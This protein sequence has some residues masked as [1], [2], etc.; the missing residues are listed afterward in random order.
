MN[1]GWWSRLRDPRG[2][3]TSAGLAL[4]AAAL[5]L[6]NLG[7]PRAFVFD[8]TYYAKDAYSLLRFGYERAFTKTA[9]ASILQG[10]LD[11]FTG[12]PAYVVHPPLGKWMIAAGEWLFGMNPFGWRIVAAV[13]GVAMVVLV[14]RIA[15]RVFINP[16]TAA[17]AGLFM[18]IDGVAIV[19]SRTALLDQF[20]TF[21]VL[22]TFYALVRDRSEYRHTLALLAYGQPVSRM[23]TARPWRLL[24]IVCIS[25]ALATKW[26]ALWFAFG[27]VLLAMWWDG[28]ERRS[29]PDVDPQAWLKDVGWLGISVLLGAATYAATWLGWFVSDAAYDRDKTGNTLLSWLQYQQSALAF[30]TNLT[31]DHPYKAAPYGW[32]LQLR[33]TSFWFESYTNGQHGCAS[34]QCSAEVLALGNPVVWWGASLAGIVL[35]A[36]FLLRRPTRIEWDRLSGPAM[37]IVAGWLPWVYFHE[38]TTFAFYSIV[39]APFM[40]L[41]FA[42][43]LTQFATKLVVLD[44]EEFSI[45]VEELHERR[46][47]AVVFVVALAVAASLFF[48]PVWVGGVLPT[49]GWQLRMW[50]PGWI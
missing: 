40:F 33:P 4:V 24:A 1:P 31:S 22:C 34:E 11:V 5:R 49:D 30:H 12:A 9:N 2:W 16:W 45:G 19:L 29:H 20:L 27:F 21:W 37:G 6:P 32:P 36:L 38:R 44:G 14:H 48:Y 3:Y 17:L 50:F 7:W 41:L 10:D 25:L 42:Y 35:L 13:I 47:Y 8:E 43:A 46:F 23:R 15:L 26:S 28:V 39:Y 18:A